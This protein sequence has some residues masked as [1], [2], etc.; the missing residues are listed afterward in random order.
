M[1]TLNIYS[2]IKMKRFPKRNYLRKTKVS[3]FNRSQR[4]F[5]QHLNIDIIGPLFK[6]TRKDEKHYNFQYNDGLNILDTPFNNDD[7]H[8]TPGKLYFSDSKNICKYLGFGDNLRKI[9]LPIDNPDFKMTKCLYGEKYGAN[10]LIFG[11]KFDLD[12]VETYQKMILMDIDIRAGNDNA[13]IIAA[14]KGNL[15]IVKFLVESGANVKSQDNCAVRLASEFGHLDVVEYLYKSGANVKADGNYAITW[16]CKNGHLPVI[17]F[18]TS[19]GA[20]IKAAQNLPIKMAAIGGHLNVIKY[21]VDRG[22]N[23]ST[24]NDYVFNIACRNGH[25]DLAEYAVSLGADI[26]SDGC[27]GIDHAIRYNHYKIVDKFIG[28]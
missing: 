14:Q 12:K 19:V 11:E 1:V 5:S 8:C 21:L 13:M 4:H 2:I 16:A 18:L 17:E 27:Y 15:E 6:I 10:M 26:F 24:D 9:S 25:T 23:I 3:F 7:D 28:T 20:D 22:A